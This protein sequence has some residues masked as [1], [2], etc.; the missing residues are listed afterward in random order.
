[1][2]GIGSSH[3]VERVLQVV[4]NDF[5]DKLAFITQ[6]IVHE[7]SD[8]PCSMRVSCVNRTAFWLPLSARRF[9]YTPK[10]NGM[11]FTPDWAFGIDEAR[12]QVVVNEVRKKG[13]QVWVR[14]VRRA[15]FLTII[16]SFSPGCFQPSIMPGVS[17]YSVVQTC[18]ATS[19]SRWFTKCFLNY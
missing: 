1:M 9:P 6:N 3:G 2:T 10:A 11:Q 19:G 5:K 18:G 14:R 13:A 7:D 4:R 12:L 16:N 15:D 17:T 8:A